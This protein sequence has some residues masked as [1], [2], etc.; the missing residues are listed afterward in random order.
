LSTLAEA[1]RP[2][3][4]GEPEPA[5]ASVDPRRWWALAVTVVAQFMIVMDAAIV[6]IAL[7]HAQR[8]LGISTADR[9]WAV[10]AYAV[11]LGGLLLLG[12]RVADLF[13]RKRT[14]V[15]A[16]VGFGIASALGGGAPTA[17]LLFVAR[18][19]QGTFA[20]VI[21]PSVPAL[22]SV[23]FPGGRER[24]RVFAILGAVSGAGATAGLLLGGVLTHYLSWRWCL[25]VTMPV[26]LLAAAVAIAVMRDNNPR[27]RPVRF[28]LL[29][30]VT[31]TAGLATLVYALT[32]AGAVGWRASTVGVLLAAAGLLAVFVV[33]ES[34]G[35]DPLVP[36]AL[37]RDTQRGA[38]YLAA[39][40]VNAAQLAAILLLT[41][42]F[43]TTLGLT[44]LAAGF[45]LLPFTA[46]VIGG[47]YVAGS[48]L[49]R[50]G[51]AR[52]LLAGATLG[53][54]GL[55]ALAGIGW[56]AGH[57]GPILPAEL[58][59]GA[60]VSV[61]IVPIS[62]QVLISVSHRNVGVAAA[63]L[64]ATQ[65]V[66]GAVGTA[67]VNTVFIAV[68]VGGGAATSVSFLFC[69]VLFA[70]VL[71]LIVV[72]MRGLRAAGARSAAE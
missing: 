38:F 56:T 11:A 2:W 51:V 60:G 55:L 18:A 72:A 31:V 47:A 43:Q 29:G 12:G 16:L 36:P 69:A 30:A 25:L 39:L 23:A 20:A 10:T 41:Y 5:A 64:N 46:G 14:F 34:R 62:S 48:L 42:Y 33:V 9:Q 19:L 61:V 21:A 65:Q 57:V 3:S 71:P 7:P 59:L 13:G 68:A 50:L 58:A 49:P 37:V 66:G 1:G 17:T 4:P 52:V 44:A 40:A 26:A 35:R 6:Y 70:L 63:L 53:L 54:A 15:V 27:T 45:A 32:L 28:D 8:D 67:L 22:A 24:D